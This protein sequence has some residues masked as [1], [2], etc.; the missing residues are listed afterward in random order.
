[1]KYK[2]FRYDEFGF[3]FGYVIT[4]IILVA[5]MVPLS[6]YVYK[7]VGENEAKIKEGMKIMGLDD[8]IYFL[9]YFIQYFCISVIVTLINTI[10]FHLVFSKIPFVF[11]YF[12]LLFFSLDIFALIYFFQSF[13]DK[14]RIAIVLSLIIYFMMY[15]F[16]LP[17]LFES[18]S[19][20]SKVL[21]SFFPLVNL[22]IGNALL[23]KFQYHFKRFYFKDFSVDHFNYSLSTTYLMFLV[24]FCI[25]LFLGFYLDNVIPHDFGIRKPWYFLCSLNYWCKNRNKRRLTNEEKLE[26]KEY[27]SKESKILDEERKSYTPSTSRSD[28]YGRSSKFESEAIYDDKSDDDVFEIRDIE[29]IYGDGK[30]A[31][32]GVNLNFY[33]DEIFALLGHNGAGKTTLISM[34]TGIY[35]ATRGKAFYRGHNI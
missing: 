2:D 4:I 15:C 35:E 32:N 25:Y 1:M 12:M 30:K 16:S 6:I 13:I 31:V 11:L 17:C 9:S 24:D 22:N 8:S 29:K 5:Y 18:S 3:F 34:L 27:N 14:T 20:N 33:R 21:F 10:L 19:Y 7:M 26:L 28:I 23:S